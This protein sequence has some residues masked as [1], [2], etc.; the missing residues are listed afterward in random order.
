MPVTFVLLA[1]A[2]LV[3]DPFLDL[4]DVTGSTF[5]LAAAV[6]MVPLAARL[7]ITGTSIPL[8]RPLDEV[9]AR[10]WLFPLGLPMLAGP[11][12]IV[13]AISYAA[14]YDEAKTVA[15]AAAVLAFTAAV[16]W[17]GPRLEGRIRASGVSALGH[18]S[19]IVLLAVA[20]EHAID[21]IRSV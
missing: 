17:A 3:S 11:T 7:V 16:V 20:F 6:F 19:G 2:A 21:G 9:S 13:A 4:I 14:R 8:P 5:Q 1:I 10:A 18:I 12:S 15:A